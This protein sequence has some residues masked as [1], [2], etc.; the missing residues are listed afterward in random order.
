MSGRSSCYLGNLSAA[1]CT[2][3]NNAESCTGN[4][5]APAGSVIVNESLVPESLRTGADVSAHLKA[6]DGFVCTGT[7]LAYCAQNGTS[8]ATV[9]EYSCADPDSCANKTCGTGGGCVDMAAP[10]DGY[11]CYCTDGYSG[12]NTTNEAASC[13]DIDDCENVTCGTGATCVD[14]SA[15][16]VGYVCKCNEGQYTGQ[17]IR[18]SDPSKPRQASCTVNPECPQLVNGRNSICDCELDL[19]KSNKDTFL[20]LS[21]SPPKNLD[22]C[23]KRQGART[24]DKLEATLTAKAQSKNRLRVCLTGTC[25]TADCCIAFTA[26]PANSGAVG[27][28]HGAP[29][30]C[31]T[32]YRGTNG[33]PGGGVA[34]LWN[35]K[36]R[37]YIGTCEPIPCPNHPRWPPSIGGM[38]ANGQGSTAC[39]CA[40][41]YSVEKHCRVDA[42]SAC[43]N[44]QLTGQQDPKAACEGAEQKIKVSKSLQLSLLTAGIH[45]AIATKCKYTPREDSVNASCKATATC[46]SATQKDCVASVDGRGSGVK[47][48]SWREKVNY[49]CDNIYVAQCEAQQ[50]SKT[51]DK[52]LYKDEK[53]NTYKNDGTEYSA[54]EFKAGKCKTTK[55]C[56]AGTQP[57]GSKKECEETLIDS[58]S[59]N[60]L[61]CNYTA[62]IPEKCS[63]TASCNDASNCK[64]TSGC[65]VKPFEPAVAQKCEPA[66]MRN[67]QADCELKSAGNKW[68]P[69]VPAKCLGGKNTPQS[70]S[71]AN[72]DQCEKTGST[73]NA[74]TCASCQGACSGTT[75]KEKCKAQAG[76]WTDAR[77]SD[78]KTAKQQDCEF[79]GNQWSVGTPSSC[80]KKEDYWN[81][82][83]TRELC[84]ND[85]TGLIWD[86]GSCKRM[87]NN[88]TSTNDCE[89]KKSGYT[90]I[91]KVN[92]ADSKCTNSQG[93]N[94]AG[95]TTDHC[96]GSGTSFKYTSGSCSSSSLKSENT[97]TKTG[98]AWKLATAGFCISASNKN[99]K[100][101]TRT[102]TSTNS[103]IDVCS[104]VDTTGACAAANKKCTTA[105]TTCVFTME[106]TTKGECETHDLEERNHAHGREWDDGDDSKGSCKAN[107]GQVT[108]SPSVN[109]AKCID[110]NGALRGTWSPGLCQGDT[111][112]AETKCSAPSGKWS[113]QKC[114]DGKSPDRNSC[115]CA[116]AGWTPMRC[117]GL[118]YAENKGKCIGTGDTWTP[119]VDAV[120]ID[121]S[122][123]TKDKCGTSRT[124]STARSG[125][126]VAGVT[127]KS[128]CEYTEN[129]WTKFK[130]TNGAG[131]IKS[132]C[133]TALKGKTGD[134]NKT[135]CEDTGHNWNASTSSCSGNTTLC[136][137]AAFCKSQACEKTGNTWVTPTDALSCTGKT[138]NTF[139]PEVF[140]KTHN[141]TKNTDGSQ[142]ATWKVSGG[143]PDECELVSSGK[144]YSTVTS[145]V[146]K[147][148]QFAGVCTP[149]I[150]S[151]PTITNGN[152][153]GELQ[154]TGKGIDITCGA[155]T[156]C[157]V[158]SGWAKIVYLSVGT[159]GVRVSHSVLNSF[160]DTGYEPAGTEGPKNKV[161]CEKA[162]HTWMPAKCTEY[163][164]AQC[165]AKTTPKCIVTHLTC[166]GESPVPSVLCF[167]HFLTEPSL[168]PSWRKLGQ[169]CA[170]VR[171][172]IVWVG[173][174]Q[175]R[176]N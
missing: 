1:T 118:V 146:F 13:T 107:D 93:S 74:G 31:H 55:T 43:L 100:T 62:P 103:S 80:S 70:Q 144:D 175:S 142:H 163:S 15:P 125:C 84:E 149:K 24:I 42:S 51:C 8:A 78:G 16:G 160:V 110:Q 53:G 136:K 157:P 174:D 38:Q 52:I 150:C 22:K 48:C 92:Q 61:V 111:G 122:V 166:T 128:K 44:V 152:S 6:K 71:P 104:K 102:C 168:N 161:D 120:C 82:R 109:K 76:T 45:T 94:V 155:S 137:S 165:R 133:S 176:R 64:K 164:T 91:P 68:T 26:C 138:G 167:L 114:S 41:G 4:L 126:I 95:N 139:T 151:R 39:S 141:C 159:P 116:G 127:S 21:Y 101:R 162:G 54:C 32:G 63:T 145:I 89:T 113:A 117:H 75:T 56:D 154:H 67:I 14:E 2:V 40:T 23:K 98:N 140:A 50:D 5:T 25:S 143:T 156:F 20:G 49:K 30:P 131:E 19:S 36:T 172:K 12:A 37:S 158:A 173:S 58:K 170:S 130:C 108:Y 79:T 90:Y 85:L 27:A 73:W 105:H 47:A 34:P 9:V 18:V 11:S 10:K 17:S 134:S 96:E 135:A 112:V 69:A 66:S 88:E 57:D 119:P 147:S 3:T 169:Q 97:C 7:A 124:W 72:E 86:A 83:N 46:T 65:T 115:V 28:G 59:P 29:C 153:A 99:K 81:P 77:C 106:A 132:F 33:G 60:G 35:Q 123:D 129:T 148:S 87:V 171:P 121:P